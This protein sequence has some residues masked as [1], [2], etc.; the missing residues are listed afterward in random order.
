MAILRH[1]GAWVLVGILVISARAALPDAPPAT[2]GFDAGRLKR[3]D[4]VIDRAIE[5]GEVPGAVVLV[6]RRGAIAYAR[7]AGQRAVEPKP[8]AMT[9]DTVFDMASLTKPIATA[10]SVL[11]LLD[12]GQLR[13]T[14]RLVRFLPEFDNH[15]KSPIII[16]HLLRHRAGFV[17]DNSL[18]D[19]KDGPDAT[20]KRIAELE[21][22]SRP[23]ERFSYSDVGFLILGRLVERVS[24]RS[25]DAF[26]EE[27][28]FDVLGM[29]DAHFRPVEPSRRPA[30]PIERIA[31]SQRET[32][33]GQMLRGIVHDPRARALGGVAGHAGLFA[34]ADDLAIFAQTLL[35]SGVGPNRRRILSP[36][37]VRTMIDTGTT[38]KGQRRGLGWDVETTYSTPRGAL[39]GPSSFGHTGFTGTSLW[40][41]PET[42]TFVVILASRLHPDGRASSPTALRAT[43]ATLAAA[44]IVDA[45]C[46]PLQASASVSSEPSAPEAP[47][48]AYSSLH[49]VQC[50]IDVLVA[51]RFRPLRGLKIGLVTNHTGLT[52]SGKSTIDVLAHAPEVKLVKLFSPEHG[53]RGA[54][55]AAVDDG[56]DDATGL[57]IISL[58]GKTRKPRPQ[59]LEGIDALV[60]DIQDIGARFYT[61]ITTLGLVIEAAR[62]SDKKVFVFD[63]PNP[64][65]G[66][67][68]SGPVRDGDL[69]SFIAY[70]A[71]PVR[72]G[73]TVGE[74]ALLYNTERKIEAKLE[75][76]K[77]RGWSR[78]QFYDHTGLVWVNPSPN[79][80][81]LTEAILYPGVGLLE[82]TNLATG[83]G[84]DTPFER[85]GAPW[86]DPI[87]FAAGLNSA[88]TPGVRFVPISFTPK[89][90]QHAGKKC[91][92][93]QILITNWSEFDPIRL[94]MVLAVQLRTQYPNEW[95][96]NGL[97]RLLCDRETY[98]N[99][100]AGKPVDVI[101]A[102]WNDELAEFQKVRSRYLLY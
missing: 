80:R 92:G 8:E 34:T 27:Q 99:V 62:E 85:V 91:G 95:Q 39:F 31:P 86:I 72:H 64:I 60:Y 81:S 70:H 19:Y 30:T 97:L 17:P 82:A 78:D 3:I 37:A 13:L 87:R 11:I 93:V 29:N 102:R 14:D 15:G 6:G 40:I 41:D 75:I 76:V 25:L 58:Y 94:G 98:E 32:P 47:S 84:T 66:R 7:A 100:R 56:K 21:L 67:S 50:G 53:I 10:T 20:W 89:E 71:L 22:V 35:N 83:R 61:Y 18:A 33:R 63:R 73:M 90:R 9:R 46:R 77:C 42:E 12:E 23:G 4:A 28:I 101:M 16:D 88:A 43:V 1:F 44:A 5:H 45:P 69:A 65:G 68:V 59:D 57:P 96:P 36:L 52:Q 49:P 79:M 54:V 26:A 55:D 2:L 74:L 24:G 51:E 38:P 48:L